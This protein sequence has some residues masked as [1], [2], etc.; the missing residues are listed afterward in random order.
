MDSKDI[1]DIKEKLPAVIKC[2]IRSLAASFPGAASLATAWSEWD[3]EKRFN[4]VK[5]FF[6]LTTQLFEEFD[7]RIK[8]QETYLASEEAPHLLSLV[9][10]KV[11]REHREEKRKR[12]AKFF[13][14]GLAVGD[15]V[16]FDEKRY[17][18]ELLDELNNFDFKILQDIFAANKLKVA[19]IKD[20]EL[21]ELVVCL[22]KLSSKGLIAETSGYELADVD[23][24]LIVGD[25]R[26][27]YNVWR[28]KWFEL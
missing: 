25:K 26:D 28:K 9:I 17:F 23:S 15:K 24:I 18:L 2:G 22:S 16:S 4:Y 8:E 20:I 12:F 7:E 5:G 11:Q 1:D 10:E 6:E 21:D 19:N 13:L 3:S 27:W 14:E